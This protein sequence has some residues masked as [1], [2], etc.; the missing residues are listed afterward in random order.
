MSNHDDLLEAALIWRPGILSRSRDPG[1][2]A[3]WG[4]L[5]LRSVGSGESLIDNS[6]LA[7]ASKAL[8]AELRGRVEEALQ[9]YQE[10]MDNSNV[11]ASTLGHCLFAWADSSGVDALQNAGESA[12]RIANKTVLCGV[13]CKLMTI[14]LDKGEL[15]T[16]Q[17]F[18]ES[19]ELLAYR[20]PA[21]LNALRWIRYR[22]LE[23][24]GFFRA[25]G[26][27]TDPRVEMRS[28]VDLELTAGRNFAK[29]AVEA[30]VRS[31]WSQSFSFGRSDVDDLYASELQAV[32]S[33]AA[34]LLPGL[35]RHLGAQLL[36]NGRSPE[37]FGHG[38]AMWIL[39]GG[40][41]L[42]NVVTEAERHFNGNT[43]EMIWN[44]ELRRGARAGAQDSMLDF[45]LS[46]W[47]LAPSSTVEWWL[48]NYRPGDDSNVAEDRAAQLWALLSVRSPEVWIRRYDD[49][50]ESKRLAVQLAMQVSV[51]GALPETLGRRFS[52]DVIGSLSMVLHQENSSLEVREHHCALA[53]SL[54][55][56]FDMELEVNPEDLQS[57]PAVTRCLLAGSNPSIAA[58]LD[59]L[60]AIRDVTSVIEDRIEA[61]HKGSYSVLGYDIWH[62]LALA[63][64]AWGEALPQTVDLMIRC[65]MDAKCSSEERVS[66]LSALHVVSQ[67]DSLSEGQM[68]SLLSLSTGETT[69]VFGAPFPSELIGI[70]QLGLVAPLLSD[71]EVHLRLLRASRNPDPRVRIVAIGTAS[72]L[73]SRRE[74]AWIDS[75][76]LS[77]LYD[78][79]RDALI[80]GLEAVRLSN[81]ESVLITGALGRVEELM[82][83]QTRHVR[84][85]VVRS[86]LRMTTFEIDGIEEMIRKA[87]ND[88]SW[89]VRFEASGRTHPVD[90]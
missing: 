31:A 60:T 33:G 49:L 42:E 47:D 39:G 32:W 7:L 3:F 36:M 80:A 21:M 63:V 62:R 74:S 18:L 35:R 73:R 79:N 83:S 41:S 19:A 87:R 8:D 76:I 57:L 69:S 70:S 54:S 66:A 23:P 22:Y 29:N 27:L 26:G 90:L 58:D 67:Q 71:Q 34:W 56:I 24:T 64:N 37:E 85:A 59:L 28:V 43:T 75:V 11:L 65:S 51:A 50:E 2:R 77:S 88:R 5:S 44:D 55:R 53:V 89:L 78:P 68:A 17:E 20:R 10:L 48:D 15:N 84:A 13:F 86:I 4:T 61:A 9:G 52:S 81:A 45:G 1:A 14:A 82:T 12:T 30:Q 25:R 6:P 38:V 40:K 16:A 46:I 72:E